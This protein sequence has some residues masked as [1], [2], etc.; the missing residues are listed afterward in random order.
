MNNQKAALKVLSYSWK[1]SLSTLDTHARFEN[2]KI[3]IIASSWAV[4]SNTKE[5][6]PLLCTKLWFFVGRRGSSRNIDSLLIV[7]T[8]L[9]D[10]ENWSVGLHL[11]AELRGTNM[12]L[13][14]LEKQ[15]V[16]TVKKEQ[17]SIVPRSHADGSDAHVRDSLKLSIY[18]RAEKVIAI[19][20][21]LKAIVLL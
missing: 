19:Q 14:S 17:S 21:T 6:G 9:L 20:L 13:G 5:P 18:C 4:A 8:A 3:D 11:W 15:K 2:I 10:A 12:F 7:G 1:M 16:P